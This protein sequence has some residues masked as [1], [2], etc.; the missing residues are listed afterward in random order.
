MVNWFIKTFFNLYYRFFRPPMV[1][2]W[3]RGDAAPARMTRADDGSYQMQIAGG[4]KSHCRTRLLSR[5]RGD[6]HRLAFAPLSNP[7]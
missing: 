7:F 5:P 1:K 6:R 3:L 2:Y 4:I